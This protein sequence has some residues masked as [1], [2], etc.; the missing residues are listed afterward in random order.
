MTFYTSSWQSAFPLDLTSRPEN[1]GKSPPKTP[2]PGQQRL[3][4]VHVPFRS[5]VRENFRNKKVKGK[6]KKGIQSI[7]L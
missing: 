1:G 5:Q 3:G 7:S 4:G 2:R 6:G